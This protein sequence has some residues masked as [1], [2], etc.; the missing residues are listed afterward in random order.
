MIFAH[1]SSVYKLCKQESKFRLTVCMVSFQ[2]TLSVFL[3]GNYSDFFHFRKTSML[4]T[5]ENTGP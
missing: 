5:G 4:P 1:L 2:F 3:I